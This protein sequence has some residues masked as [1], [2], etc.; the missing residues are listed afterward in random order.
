M[1]AYEVNESG[2]PSIH[3]LPSFSRDEMTR[4]VEKRAVLHKTLCQTQPLMHRPW[5]IDTLVIPSGTAGWR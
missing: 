4:G 5:I 2:D 1:H 3:S